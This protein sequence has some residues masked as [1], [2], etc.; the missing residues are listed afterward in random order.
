[1]AITTEASA[2][3]H[4]AEQLKAYEEANRKAGEDVRTVAK[5]IVGGVTG[6]AVGVIAGS[7]L[8]SLGALGWEIRLLIA[9]L[10]ALTGF[11]TLGFLL[12]FSLGVIT[13]RSYSMPGIVAGKDI[14]P[15]RL[16]KIEP[17]VRQ[18]F[19]EGITSLEQFTETGLR[20]AKA[21]HEPGASTNTKLKDA[22]F[23]HKMHLIR[24]ALIYQHLLLLFNELKHWIFGLTPVIALAFGFYAWAVGPHPD[25]T[26]KPYVKSIPVAPQ[27]AAGLA[28]ALSAADCTKNPTAVDV[29]VTGERASGAEDVITVPKGNCP[30]LRLRLDG[31][32]LTQ[33]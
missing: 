21:V 25:T 28:T 31:G 11:V 13:P 30:P 15:R 18:L 5:W 22:E 2:A 7:L 16:K 12:W 19:P 29:I 6:T 32:R 27:D 3:D 24:S 23:R 14:K 1:M 20:H 26:L 33:Q 4:E 9:V 8:T 10:G 17:T